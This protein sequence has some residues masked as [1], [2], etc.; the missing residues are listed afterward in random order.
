MSAKAW[1]NSLQYK[2]EKIYKRASELE[3]KIPK[4]SYKD[5]RKLLREV[6]RI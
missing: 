4:L 6:K 1:F 3:L 2:R 5:F